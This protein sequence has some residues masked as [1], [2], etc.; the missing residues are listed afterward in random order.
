MDENCTRFRAQANLLTTENVLGD[1]TPHTD[2]PPPHGGRL[3]TFVVPYY[4][5]NGEQ[6]K[7]TETDDDQYDANHR[8]YHRKYEDR[9]KPLY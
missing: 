7:V 2:T 8:V 1:T 5:S 4:N 9:N 6:G 3:V